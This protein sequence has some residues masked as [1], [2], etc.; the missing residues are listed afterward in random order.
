MLKAEYTRKIN[1]SI[2]IITPEK[3]F[4]AEKESI[5]MFQYNEI[6]YFLKMGTQRKNIELQF[7]YDITSQRSLNQ[8]LEFKSL[9]Y[10][11]LQMILDSFDQACMQMEDFMLTE[12]DIMMKPEYI[13]VDHNMEHVS[14][15]YL[16]GFQSDI[17]EQFKDFMEY[18]LQHLN[19]KDEQAMQLAYGVYQKVT[20]EKT[21]LHK[22]LR[23]PDLI[24]EYCVR[25]V[26]NSKSLFEKTD[27]EDKISIMNGIETDEQRSDSCETDK[28][29]SYSGTQQIRIDRQYSGM[30]DT[31]QT[32]QNADVNNERNLY[33][34]RE[35]SNGKNLYMEQEVSSEEKIR[36]QRGIGSEEKIQVQR[37]KGNREKIQRQRETGNGQNN[38]MKEESGDG[39][40]IMYVKGNNQQYT[41]MDENGKQDR[42]K[43]VNDI[44]NYR[45]DMNSRVKNI[46]IQYKGM[47]EVDT[48][49]EYNQMQEMKRSRE[50]EQMQ[51]IERN[52][53]YGQMQEMKRNGEHEQRQVMGR[54]REYEQRQAE[55]KNKEYEQMQAAGINVPYRG[56][57]ETGINMPYRG[58]QE[59]GITTPYR[60]MQE[61]EIDTQDADMWGEADTSIVT[62]S[63]KSQKLKKCIGKEGSVSKT[64]N[65]QGGRK[66]K[67][68]LK[69]AEKLQ[70]L[71]QQE[72]EFGIH[73][74]DIQKKETLRRQAAEKLKSMLMKKIYTD[75]IKN[76]NENTVFE[77]DEEEL[78][79]N[80]PTVCLIQ[81]TDDTYNRF[82][83]QGADRSRDFNCSHGKLLIGSAAEESDICIPFP[84]I[85]RV[86]AVIQTDEQ[87]TFLEDMN[88]TN[89]THVNGELLQYHERRMLK[90]GDIISLAGECY[91]F[92]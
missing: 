18:L 79:Q 87:G 88:S 4:D 43:N 6:P 70:D 81:E 2:L 63:R 35:V 54:S 55:D 33:L 92:H 86:H 48:I 36:M 38:L 50:H 45:R 40:Y 13:F 1:N 12:N 21:A 66:L 16:P 74:E 25:S 17:C 80:N 62:G 71:R 31:Q 73:S 61:E 46:S 10:A 44:E 14:Y 49:R 59:T 41:C 67:N 58:M 51:E 28:I 82:I 19:H 15:C 47:R 7:C 30:Q 20:E 75:R 57:Q 42:Y 32:Q 64:E 29:E 27:D 72:T 5:S 8:L 34:K 65:R 24:K 90:K 26:V 60:R 23:E 52:R 39:K 83:Y 9:D 91:S 89:G 68:R 37:E 84:M 69:K 56:M 53:K 85:S 3:D 77:A 76:E 11:I 22:V 78:M